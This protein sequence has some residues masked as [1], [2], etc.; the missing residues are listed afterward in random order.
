MGTEKNTGTQQSLDRA[1]DL[2]D[3]LAKNESNGLNISEI[4]KMLGISRVT[5][6]TMVQT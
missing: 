5:A 6:S 1:L 4:S 3:I 2:L